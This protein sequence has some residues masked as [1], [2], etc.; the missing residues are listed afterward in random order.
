[1]VDTVSVYVCAGTKLTY[2][3]SG[4]CVLSQRGKQA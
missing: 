2:L 1:M 3:F 4:V